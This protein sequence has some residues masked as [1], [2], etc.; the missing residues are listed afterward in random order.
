MR[1]H[2]ASIS[3]SEIPDLSTMIIAASASLLSG[4]LGKRKTPRAVLA[5]ALGSVRS[6]RAGVPSARGSRMSAQGEPVGGPG[7]VK[8]VAPALRSTIP[9]PHHRRF[10]PED[11]GTKVPPIIRRGGAVCQAPVLDPPPA[12]P[13][14]R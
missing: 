14:L 2:T 13:S 10:L 1:R 11:I 8:I 5:A 6:P 7:K 9:R 4:P 3:A 12:P